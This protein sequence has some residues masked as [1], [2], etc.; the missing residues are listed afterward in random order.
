MQLGHHT[1]NI[2]K[3][4]WDRS[5]DWGNPPELGPPL[6]E[7]GPPRIGTPLTWDPPGIGTPI[8]GT[9]P[10]LGPPWNWDP[11]ELGPPQK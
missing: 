5:H 6:L 3:A 8:I 7:L 1:G 2:K 11:P 10:E 4:L 9:L